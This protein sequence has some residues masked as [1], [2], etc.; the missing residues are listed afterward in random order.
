M[1]DDI[2]ADLILTVIS[3]T[4]WTI[5]Y[6]AAIWIGFRQRTYAMPVAALAL[7]LAWESIYAGPDLASAYPE[8]GVIDIVWAVADL[9]IVYTFLRFGRKEFPSLTR[10]MFGLWAVLLF[11][12]AY[13]VQLLFVNEFGVDDAARYSAFLQNLLMSVLFIAMFVARQG[14][15]GQ[16]LTIAVF[17]WI[18][19]LAATILYGV[20]ESSTFIL[21]LGIMCCVFDIVYIGLVVWAKRR[22]D[23]LS[24]A[25]TPASATAAPEGVAAA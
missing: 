3:G 16:G 23:A 1:T 4:A 20:I 5:V 17:K 11:G 7:N 15:R 24:G 22:P 8:Q 6:I 19:T 2:D 9:I 10:R 14:I 13:A 12:T 18:G 25:S 21:G